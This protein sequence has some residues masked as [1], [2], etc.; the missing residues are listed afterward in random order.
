MTT[1]RK[2]IEQAR[3]AN[4][5][6]LKQF[7]KRKESGLSRKEFAAVLY[8]IN[9]MTVYDIRKKDAIRLASEKYGVPQKLIKALIGEMGIK[10][11]RARKAQKEFGYYNAVGLSRHRK[12]TE[13]HT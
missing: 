2:I 12:K 6:E 3:E 13:D 11:S 7:L 9:G 8:A 10:S 1:G 4:F 5:I